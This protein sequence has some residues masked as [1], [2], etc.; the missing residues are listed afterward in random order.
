MKRYII[1]F[2]RGL[3]GILASI[4]EWFTVVLGMKDDSKYGKVLRRI[5]GTCFA[6]VMLLLTAAAVWDFGR[7]ACNRLHWNSSDYISSYN[8][9]YLSRN[10]TYHE[11]YD[12]D[13][14]VFNRDGEKVIKDVRW[15]AKPLGDDSLV[16]YRAGKKRG[17]FNIFTGEITIKPQYSHAWI[18][19]DGLAA[20]EE[21]GWIKFIDTTGKVVIDNHLPYLSGK[22]GYVFHNGYCVVHNNKGDRLGLIDKRGDWAIK[23]EYFSVLPVDSLWVVSNGKEKSVLSPRLET[24]LPFTSP[25]VWV[26]DGLIYASMEDHSVRTYSLQGELVEDFHISGTSQLLYETNEVYYTFSKNYNDEGNLV[27]ETS[28]GDIA[29]RQSVAHCLRY[30][31][32]FDWYG[33]MTPEGLAVTPPLYREIYAIGPDLYLCKTDYQ[34]GV[35]LNGKGQKVKQMGFESSGKEY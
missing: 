21:D 28:D 19:S 32:A 35:I 31:A 5:V 15:I 30:Q 14:Y 7:T 10:L 8:N 4:A 25:N 24:I 11:G 3:T 12:F 26:N 34:Y 1:L 23:P 9:Q 29:T 27:S 18:F 16:C 33:L 22:D 20:V 17:Y 13:G 6:I 2:W